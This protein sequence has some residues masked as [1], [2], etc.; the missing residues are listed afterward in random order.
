MQFPFVVVEP[1]GEPDT[2]MFI[3]MQSDLMK[4]LVVSNR[5]LQMYGD[6]EVIN[7]IPNLGQPED[8]RAGRGEAALD[9]KLR[10]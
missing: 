7:E 6:L 2:E 1:S 9:S 4:I 8:G 5:N 3:K 10:I